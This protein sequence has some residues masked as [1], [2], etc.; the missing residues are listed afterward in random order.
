[1]RLVR[2]YTGTVEVRLD[3][4]IIIKLSEKLCETSSRELAKTLNIDETLVSKIKNDESR[5]N[6]ET[7]E[8]L[9]K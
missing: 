7:R 5:M 8:M 9:K 4:L 6:D 2:E 3:N 1:M